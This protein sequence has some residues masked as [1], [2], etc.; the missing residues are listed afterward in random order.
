MNKRPGWFSSVLNLRC[1]KCRK[2]QMFVPVKQFNDWFKMH[3]D[4]P[5]CKTHL[6]MEPGFYWGAMYVSYTIC[7]GLC[8]GLFL[9]AYFGFGWTLTGSFVFLTI[10]VMLSSPYVYRLS[11]CIWFSA[12]TRYDPSI[13]KE[14]QATIPTEG[15]TS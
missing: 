1:A 11:R 3:D 14:K 9:L 8:F 10:L 4:C 13:L 7:S 5:R 15:E 12:F 6:Y 2:G